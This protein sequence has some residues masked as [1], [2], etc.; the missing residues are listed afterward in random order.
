MPAP[1]QLRCSC[2]NCRV[3][4][5]IFPVLLISVGLLFLIGEYTRYSFW[6]LWPLLLIVAGVMAVIQA[7]VPREG[8]VS[9]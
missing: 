6:E 7:L 8:H 3:R 9:Y 1:A 2:M 5:A 4:G